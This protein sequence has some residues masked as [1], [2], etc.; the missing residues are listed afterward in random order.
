MS[1][2]I[3]LLLSALLVA[4]PVFAADVTRGPAVQNVDQDSAVIGVR[5]D[6]PCDVQVH[7]G[8]PDQLTQTASSAAATQHFVTLGSLQPATRYAYE[9]EACGADTG[10]GGS[11]TTAPKDGARHVHFAAVG[12]FGTGDS[13][14]RQVADALAAAHPEF[15]LT[16]GDDAY[17]SGSESDFDQRFFAPMK[18]LLANVPVFPSPGNHEYITNKAQPYLDAF[19]LPTNNPAGSERYYSFDWG[20]VHVV[21]LDSMCLMGTSS[22]DCTAAAQKAWLEQDLAASHAPWKVVSFHHPVY[23]SGEHGSTP[24][25]QAL[26][27]VFEAGGVDLVLT[28]HDHDYERTRPMK[29]GVPVPEGTPGAVTYLVV[30]TGGAGAYDFS[31]TPSWVAAQHT[32]ILGYLDVT[33]EGGTLTGKLVTVD[34]Q[35]PDVF[36]LKKALPPPTLQLLTEPQE[37]PA[38]LTVHFTATSDVGDAAIAWDF[39]DGATATGSTVEHTFQ[40]AGQYT[41][42]ATATSGDQTA[43]AST[44]VTV[45]S[46]N[47]TTPPPPDGGIPRPGEDTGDSSGSDT[48]PAPGNAPPPDDAG[49]EAAA[50][51]TAL[52][53]PVSA[54]AGLSLLALTLLSRRRCRQP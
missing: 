8:P 41:V 38:P 4:A 17:E 10:L 31:G 44:T 28:G 6:A 34:G 22:S 37:G 54:V 43:T 7:F 29:G 32:G 24:A 45:R 35:T 48:R 51:C 18:P 19:Q 20:A 2:R 12:D 42:K 49:Q 15:W 23:S 40:S 14:Q 39:G 30:G 47:G 5:L 33:V 11:F 25:M 50:G 27:P 9:V 3:P 36:T 21:S 26:M 1:L 53:S 46:G 16:L 13:R 52:P